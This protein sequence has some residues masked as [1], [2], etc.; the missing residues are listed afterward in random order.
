MIGQKEFQCLCLAA[1]ALLSG[2]CGGDEQET[3]AVHP[4]TATPTNSASAPTSS[5]PADVAVSAVFK[6]MR[7]N[8]PQVLW[9]FLPPSYQQDVNNL[10]HEFAGKMDAE[11][12]SRSSRFSRRAATLLSTRKRFILDYPPLQQADL[13]SFDVKSLM[14][15]WDGI[16]ELLSIL[17]NSDLTDLDKLKTIDLGSY[18]A[19]TGGQLMT[20]LSEM[21]AVDKNDPFGS[22]LRKLAKRKASLVSEQGETAVVKL[23]ST[24]PQ[25]EP[26]QLEF[27]RV[28]GKWIPKTLADG[29]SKH[30]EEIRVQMQASLSAETIADKKA[31]VFQFLD[32]AEPVLDLLEQ[33]ETADDFHDI[34]NRRVLPLILG[35][36]SPPRDAAGVVET[37]ADDAVVVVLDVELDDSAVKALEPKLQNLADSPDSDLV[38]PDIEG[39]TMRFT[40]SPAK[41]VELVA[42]KIDFGKVLKV[43]KQKRIIYVELKKPPQKTESERKE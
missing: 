24:D 3:P 7:E 20:H 35:G 30:V 4:E 39:G 40:V 38:G 29:W 42:K 27:A 17:V 16:V 12:W 14:E 21:S 5:E 1:A 10:A 2:G 8:K 32:Q 18:L 22:S 43:D 31:D 28:E 11:L 26:K 9:E 23:E 13:P 33:A 36:I 19:Q 34:L 41:D 15:R 37:P 6:G 25:Q